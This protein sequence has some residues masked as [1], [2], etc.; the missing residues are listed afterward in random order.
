[1]ELFY[2]SPTR[3]TPLPYHWHV[4]F[5]S[6]FI[7]SIWN[8]HT[9]TAQ[10]SYI[11]LLIASLSKDVVVFSNSV[12]NTSF[13]V[14]S[15]INKFSFEE[16]INFEIRVIEFMEVIEDIVYEKHLDHI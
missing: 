16:K 10:F 14:I 11:I 6:V 12:V 4:N 9:H 15:Y 5:F 2:I 7:G 1:M 13:A 8:T 3:V